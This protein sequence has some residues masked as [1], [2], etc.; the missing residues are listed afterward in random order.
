M[1]NLHHTI[2]ALASEFAHALLRSLRGASLEE[3]LTEVTHSGGAAP[4]RRG[5]PAGGGASHAAP[6]AAAPRKRGG[7]L[8]RRS[9]TDITTV[10]GK[11]LTL[12]Q[13]HKNGLRAEEIRT[14]LDLDRREIPRP[15]AEALK[16]KMI[17]KKG[18]KRAT[19]YYAGK[20]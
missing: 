6:A 8:H 7:R 5:R 17:S 2:N 4:R 3:I 1:S 14:K 9:A 10:A 12:L 15:L 19:T 20:K 16:K 13:T 18:K 11:I